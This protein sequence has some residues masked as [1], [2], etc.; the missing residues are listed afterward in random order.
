MVEH[1]A[2]VVSPRETRFVVEV[3]TA[4][5]LSFGAELFTRQVTEA[6]LQLALVQKDATRYEAL[7]KLALEAGRCTRV[8]EESPE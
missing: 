8:L 5:P 7:A 1:I 4:G 2:A 6:A 3:D